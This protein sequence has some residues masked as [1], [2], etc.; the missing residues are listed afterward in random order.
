MATY[1]EVKGVTIQTLDEDPVENVGTWSSQSGMNEGRKGLSGFGTYTASIAATG[2]DPSTVNSVESWNGS[3]WTE[4]A[5]VNTAKFYR[6]NNG[7]Q[8]A[9]LLIGGAPATTDT[10]EWNGSAWTETANYPASLYGII[11]LGTQTAAFC[12]GGGDP[13]VT[14]TNTYDGSSFTSSTAIN[15]GRSNGIGSGLTTAAVIAGGSTPSATSN[16]ELWNGSSWTEVSELNTARDL[17]AGSGSSST[18]SLAFGGLS[19]ALASTEIWNGTTWTETNDL[20]TGRRELGGSTNGSNTQALAF[21]GCTSP[22]AVQTSTEQWEFPPVTQA[23]LKEGLMF[24]SGG[25]TL[26]AFGKAVPTGT[27][28]AGN[29]LNTSRQEGTTS[30]VQTASIVGG[31]YTTTYVANTEIY[32]GTSWSEESD[33]NNAGGGMAP[34]VRGSTSATFAAGGAPSP[35]PSPTSNEVEFWNGSS[36][37]EG[38]D[39]NE[40]RTNAGGAGT[41]TSGLVFMGYY[42]TYMV[43]TEEYDGTSWTEVNNLNNA[44]YGSACIGTQTAALATGRAGNPTKS[45]A[46]EWDGTSW[47]NITDQN[48]GRFGTGGGGTQTQGLM[49]AGNENPGAS[50]KTELWNGTSWTELNDLNTG[51]PAYQAGCGSGVAAL[52]TNGDPTPTNHVE[53]WTATEGILTVTVS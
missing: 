48:T 44:G 45:K 42:P 33:M 13:Y 46:E 12:I 7:T 11:Q 51:S 4:I 27:W 6:G 2:N 37:S 40:E 16:T 19:T 43:D 26:K 49:F 14:A 24:L 52:R 36:W 21:S 23:K 1:K 25:T 17:L 20:G 29:N 34:S 38:A 9:G 31:G 35:T 47:T 28:A 3:A 41:S 30:G 5:E 32:D 10:E 8:T 15:T 18:N 22:G 53:E 39:M 50:A